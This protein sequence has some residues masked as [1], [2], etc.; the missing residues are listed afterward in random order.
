MSY[1]FFRK[2]LLKKYVN[3]LLAD[4]FGG[5]MKKKK[6]KCEAFGEPIFFLKKKIQLA[7]GLVKPNPF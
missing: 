6:K 7:L 3:Q 1:I 5:E 4:S 2:L